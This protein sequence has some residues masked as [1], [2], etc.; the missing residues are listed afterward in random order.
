MRL[1]EEHLM[2]KQSQTILTLQVI[3]KAIKNLLR[4]LSRRL[5]GNGNDLLGRRGRRKNHV[6]YDDS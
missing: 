6:Q 4:I 3:L 2:S 5:R 1:M